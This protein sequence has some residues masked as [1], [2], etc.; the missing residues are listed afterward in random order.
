MCGKLLTQPSFER[1]ER[2]CRSGGMLGSAGEDLVA[3]SA[4]D[5]GVQSGPKRLVLQVAS[6]PTQSLAEK[7]RTRARREGAIRYTSPCLQ[8][9]RL[10]PTALGAT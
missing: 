4:R 1:R 5:P 10:H 3:A 6:A 9:D 2:V 8:I 7:E